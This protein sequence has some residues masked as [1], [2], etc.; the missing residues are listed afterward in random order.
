MGGL[1]LL[2][3][4]TR[5]LAAVFVISRKCDLR[6]RRESPEGARSL[7]KPREA[8][9]SE[10]HASR[11]KVRGA[12]ECANMEVCFVRQL[13]IAAGKGGAAAGAEAT[14]HAGRGFVLC[15]F[16]LSH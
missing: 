2:G 14:L 11:R 13:R 9:F 16:A 6:E 12:I 5:N 4:C 1:Q 8:L 3:V 7:I 10:E 15:D